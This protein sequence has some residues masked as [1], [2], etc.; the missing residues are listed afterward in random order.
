VNRRP[1][2]LTAVAGVLVVAVWWFF[3]WSPKQ[4]SLSK[5]REGRTA[6]E[7]QTSQLRTKLAQLEVI[8]EQGPQTDAELTRLAGYVPKDPQ[9][10]AFMLTANDLAVQSGIDWISVT[11]GVPTASEEGGPSSI[12]LQI[13][14]Q[15]TFF[16]TLD[17]LHRL[18][19]MPRLVI[20]DELKLSPMSNETASEDG[21]TT[22]S[23][24]PTISAAIT[25]RMF[26]QA[27]A[28]AARTATGAAT[29]T[30]P[31]SA[32]PAAPTPSEGS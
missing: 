6:A 17:Y 28:A 3:V 16:E 19:K 10:A 2:V 4:D 5:A 26:V 29:G 30:P 12:A 21:S 7:S 31:A 8:D 23:N 11:P 32:E 24:N 14:V 27:P 9:L 20:T 1:L 22:P 13:E 18:E 15:G 25:A